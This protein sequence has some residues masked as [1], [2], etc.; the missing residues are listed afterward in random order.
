VNTIREA[1]TRKLGPLKAWHWLLIVAGGAFIYYR[2]K[3]AG[4][5]PAAGTAATAAAAQPQQPYGDLSGYD[6]GG[7]GAGGA[8]SQQPGASTTPVSWDPTQAT[9][10]PPITINITPGDGQ[11]SDG[12]APPGDG[13][14]PDG[15]DGKPDHGGGGRP[16]GA[17][18]SPGGPATRHGGGGVVRPGKRSVVAEIQRR[19]RRV[20]RHGE[21]TPRHAQPEL[22][23]E[24]GRGGGYTPPR[25]APHA[26][27]HPQSVGGARAREETRPAVRRNVYVSGR[28]RFG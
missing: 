6:S 11:P 1:L 9:P 26:G 10:P 21:P 13:G 20:G 28:K 17:R 27:G 24:H 12:G 23:S 2:R 5:A 14:P 19:N 18:V 25:V 7:A 15:G 22:V 3:G 4:A 8:A 16:G